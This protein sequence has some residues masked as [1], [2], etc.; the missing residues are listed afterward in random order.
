M[1]IIVIITLSLKYPVN[2]KHITDDSRSYSYDTIMSKLNT[3]GWSSRKLTRKSPNSTG[4]SGKVTVTKG[5]IN[6]TCC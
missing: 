5:Q 6:K 2:G 4:C 1:V 3:N